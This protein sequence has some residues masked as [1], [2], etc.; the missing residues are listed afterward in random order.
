M[1]LAHTND[2]GARILAAGSRYGRGR[3]GSLRR[4]AA[5]DTGPIAYISTVAEVTRLTIPAQLGNGR[6]TSIPTTKPKIS[7]VNGTPRLSTRPRAGGT[8]PLRARP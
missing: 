7:E 1:R 8:Y 2:S 5:S 6:N 4:S 3:S